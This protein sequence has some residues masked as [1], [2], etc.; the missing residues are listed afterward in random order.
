MDMENENVYKKIQEF[1]G[2][3]NDNFSLMEDPVD[4][5]VQMIY[6]ETSG[7]MRGTV[8]EDDMLARKDEL[9]DPKLPVEDK[10][11][12]M[13]QMAGIPSPEIYRALES[14]AKNPDADLK[15]WSKLALQDNRLLLESHLLDSRQV[16][17]S[18]GLGGK[19]HKLRYF[20]VLINRNGEHLKPFQQK[21]V[22]DEME[23]ALQKYDSELEKLNFMRRYTT[24]RVVVPISSDLTRM[25]REGIDECNQ[26]GDFLASDFI[27]TNMKEMDED[28][29]TEAL[30]SGRN[31]L[32]DEDDDDFPPID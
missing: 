13:V 20:V 21:M 7:K 1:F 23:Y 4:V 2:G 15:D 29:I 27:V 31:A 5:A 8:R 6:F 19:G 9:F 3:L 28:E 26:F 32:A 30:S 14:Y 11:T 10:K 25:F 18:T 22:Q 17:I 16:F 24:M 12:L